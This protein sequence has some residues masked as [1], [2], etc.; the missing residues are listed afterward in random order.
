MTDAITFNSTYKYSTAT[1][2]EI[3]RIVGVQPTGMWDEATVAGVFEFQ[4]ALGLS[5]DGKVDPLTL[6]AIESADRIDDDEDHSNELDSSELDLLST[7]SEAPSLGDSVDDGLPLE[8]LRQWCAAHNT[9]L[10]DFR[11]LKKWPRNKEYPKEYGYPLNKKRAEPP[12]GGI[13]RKWTEITSFMLHT[14]AVA[15]MKAKRGLGIPCHLYLPKENAIVLCHELELYIYHGHAGN[16][17]SVGLEISG[18]SDWDSTSQ[19][20]RARELLRYFQA[21]R[22]QKLGPEAKCKVMAHRMSHSSRPNDPGK[23]IW[24]DAGEWAIR[25]LGFEMGSVCGT[26]KNKGK[27]IDPSWR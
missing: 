20:D 19:I 12:Q 15:G 21:I 13:R 14:T 2:Q 4:Q 1:I 8:Q 17:C 7:E 27:P 16:S 11:D 6:E 24:R 25:E 26:G 22:R 3:Q 18:N 23:N 5:A 9:E 10:I